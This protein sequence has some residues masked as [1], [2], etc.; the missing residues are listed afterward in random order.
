MARGQK[1]EEG[2]ER[3]A[4]NGY[5]YIKE[6]GKWRL[7]H[8]VIMEKTLGRP[9]MEWERVTFKDR[10]KD[11]LSPDNLVLVDKEGIT[12]EQ[13][14]ARIDREISNLT[15]LREEIALQAGLSTEF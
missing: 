4:P 6:N 7:K 2:S 1:S 9:L 13:K 10:N 5:H 8:H 14:I 12:P 11:N 15:H 3:T